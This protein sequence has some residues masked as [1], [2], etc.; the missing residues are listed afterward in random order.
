MSESS[1]RTEQLAD[2]QRQ[3]RELRRATGR[4]RVHRHRHR[5]PTQHPLRHTPACV[6]IQP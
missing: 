3:Y 1:S 5:D 4:Y 2:Y 6:N